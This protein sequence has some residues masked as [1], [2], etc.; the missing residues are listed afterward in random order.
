MAKKKE[1][2]K[3][4]IYYALDESSIGEGCEMYIKGSLKEAYDDIEKDY[5]DSTWYVYEVKL[6][7]KLKQNLEIVKI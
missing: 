5:K 4:K 7:G 3:K 2:I 1:I 6:V